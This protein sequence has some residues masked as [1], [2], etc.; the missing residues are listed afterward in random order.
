MTTQAWAEV[1]TSADPTLPLRVVV[2]DNDPDALDLAITD[3][4]LEGH[5]VIGRALDGATGIA[6]CR[7]LRPD[8]LVV[9]VRMPPGPDGVAVVRAL[10][11]LTSMRCIV[12]TNYH[13]ARLRRDVTALGA[14][15]LQKG[16]LAALRAAVAG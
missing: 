10:R 11:D 14:V 1:V 13:H 6:L 5:H 12:Y 15:F 3:L 16:E 8:V 9:D 7:A 4:T 2:V